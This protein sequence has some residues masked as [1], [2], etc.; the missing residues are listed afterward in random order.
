M[1]QRELMISAL[2]EAAEIEHD[3]TC[4][5]LFAAF[6][7]KTH[8]AE[9]GV[10]WP[11]LERIRQWKTD[12][13]RIARQEMAHH[14]L[15]SNLL[16]VIGGAPQFRRA[17]F[18][19][20]VRYCPPYQTFELLPFGAPALE[21]FAAY[22]LAHAPAA[23]S[24][25]RTIGTLYRLVREG[26]AHAGPD[27]FAG[28]TEHQIVNRHLRI[29]EGQFDIDLASADD[30][31]SA[32]AL[33]DRLLDHDHHER[34][35]AILDELRTLKEADPSFEPARPV[36]A[37]PRVHLSGASAGATVLEHPVTRAAAHLFNLAY[38][39]MVLMLSRLYGRTDESPAEV[40][41][42]LH[43]AFFPLMTVVIR[44]LGELLTQMPAEPGGTR[45]AGP[46]FELPLGLPLPPFKRGAW[47]FLHERL[48][49]M[50]RSGRELCVS[51]DRLGEPWAAAMKPR[52]TLLSENLDRMAQRFEG[53]MSLARERVLQLLGRIG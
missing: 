16:V 23:G 25:E 17:H 2:S 36:V 12:L 31:A 39:A 24:G 20:P 10:D 45:A 38:E 11:R 7:L 5:Y 42:L 9:G 18:P 21:R 52:V 14:A 49:D 19:H 37:N 29:G 47:V 51:L 6:S 33:V 27:L 22:E 41:A 8:I 28:P 43:M 13:L 3:I 1:S 50:A 15:V 32:A 48:E 40:E 46:C 26:L 53:D 35:V 30:G 34:F 44:P 4:Q